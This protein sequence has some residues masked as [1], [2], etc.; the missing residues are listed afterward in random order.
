MFLIF[1]Q[2]KDGQLGRWQSDK[3][4]GLLTMA[5]WQTGLEHRAGDPP[6]QEGSEPWALS[7]LIMAPPTTCTRLTWKDRRSYLPVILFTRSGGSAPSFPHLQ[8]GEQKL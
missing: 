6:C 7:V 3:E 2:S 1:I 5:P 4:A 8:S